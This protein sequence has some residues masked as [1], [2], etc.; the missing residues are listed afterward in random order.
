MV[1]GFLMTR[2]TV[3]AK[4]HELKHKRTHDYS[5]VEQVFFPNIISSLW[6][7]DNDDDD[8]EEK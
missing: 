8:V 4:W 3:D 1:T 6:T 2:R 5:Y 7:H